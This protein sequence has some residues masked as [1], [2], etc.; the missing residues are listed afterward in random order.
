MARTRNDRRAKPIGSVSHARDWFAR[1][2]PVVYRTMIG[3]A[4]LVTIVSIIF[5]VVLMSVNNRADQIGIV[6]RARA[7]VELLPQ[8]V[9]QIERTVSDHVEAMQD[10]KNRAAKKAATETALERIQLERDHIRIELRAL[11]RAG[12]KANVTTK[13]RNTT[14]ELAS[15]AEAAVAATADPDST[16]VKQVSTMAIAARADISTMP[17]QLDLLADAANAGAGSSL[18]WAA[19]LGFLAPILTAVTAAAVAY[20]SMNASHAA[21]QQI[22]QA[23]DT[24]ATRGERRELDPDASPMHGQLAGPYARMVMRVRRSIEELESWARTSNV[25]RSIIESVE[26]VRS[27][28]HMAGAVGSSF[29]A[30]SETTPM[31]LII[32]SADAN[33]MLRVASSPVAGAPGCPVGSPKYCPAMRAES[34]IVYPDSG[35]HTACPQ[36]RARE[37]PC[38][39]A[40]VPVATASQHLGVIHVTAPT[41]GQLD[42]TLL[43]HTQMLAEVTATK[44]SQ[45]RTFEATWRKATTDQLT[46]LHNRRAFED[47]A[48]DLISRNVP[49]ILVMSD[50]DHFKLLNDRFG[51]KSGD[52]VL[53]AFAKV[54]RENIRRSDMAARF[55]GEEFLMLLPEATMDE[56]I[57][58]L[59]RVRVALGTTL[60]IAG[61]PKTTASFGVTASES[62][63]DLESVLRIA[64][65]GLYLAKERGRDRVERADLHTVHQI[66]GARDTQ[67]EHAAEA[68]D[69]TLEPQQQRNS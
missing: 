6:G 63:T 4:A 51:H 50:L 35:S 20:Q 49:F 30:I 43:R 69:V 7:S 54:L 10:E 56:A 2:P 16:S 31:E 23:L 38:A 25:E 18:R 24:V 41:V 11:T 44:L 61:L 45:L 67:A 17:P 65:A 47:R 46:G 48:T 21:S 52:E 26:A 39:A 57:Y 64:D 19:I 9:D 3:G 33:R 27:R 32:T 40:C 14:D 12:I 60:A 53:K 68:T 28:S 34:T 29:Q 66:F 36:L 62:G 55:G 5:G 13:V 37:E 8:Y 1:M 22:G 15:T 58:T 59:E 42:D